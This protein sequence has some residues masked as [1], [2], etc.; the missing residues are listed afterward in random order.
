MNDF[1][2]ASNVRLRALAAERGCGFL[3]LGYYIQDHY[4]RMPAIYSKDD[5]HMND[6]GSLAWMRIMRFYAQ[7]EQEGGTL[8]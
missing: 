2:S 4:G 7:Y 1:I 3:D 6:E 8:S 5:F